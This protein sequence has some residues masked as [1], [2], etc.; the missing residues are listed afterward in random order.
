MAPLPG[1]GRTGNSP[2]GAGLDVSSRGP[3]LVDDRCAPHDQPVPHPMNGLRPSM[4]SL[5][6]AA[7]TISRLAT[8][9]QAATIS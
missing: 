3:K 7:T 2:F 1:V 5:S 4:I 9:N 6:E 8:G